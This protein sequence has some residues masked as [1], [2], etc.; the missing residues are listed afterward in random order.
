MMDFVNGKDDIPYMK[1]KISWDDYSQYMEKHIY[2]Y[3][4]NVPNHQPGF[5]PPK[6]GIPLHEIC[7]KHVG[8]AL[9]GDN[10]GISR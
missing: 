7:G 4:Y 3:I 10:T 8:I 9:H 2:I 1:W 6:I 5:K